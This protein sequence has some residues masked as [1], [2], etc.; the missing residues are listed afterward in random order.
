MSKLFVFCLL[1]SSALG[2]IRNPVI[3]ERTPESVQQLPLEVRQ[4]L[5]K[6]QCLIPKYKMLLRLSMALTG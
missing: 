1:T 6:R 2:Q 3:K 4:D 5:T